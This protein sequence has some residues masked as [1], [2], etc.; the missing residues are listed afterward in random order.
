MRFWP[1]VAVSGHASLSTRRLYS[2]GLDA[3][4]HGIVTA[5]HEGDENSADNEAAKMGKPAHA[6]VSAEEGRRKLENEPEAD[7]PVGG[8]VQW[9]ALQEQTP[10]LH[11]RIK[12]EIG[13]HH[14]R[15]AA[16]GA[17]QRAVR[18]RGDEGMGQARGRPAEQEE[19]DETEMPHGILH[20]VAEHPEKQHVSDQVEQRAVQEDVGGQC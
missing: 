15:Y 5:A 10:D 18:L 11:A 3:G 12:D 19:Q 1:S 7:G 17:D 6:L 13:R 16:G 4:E 20:I 2:L 9:N 14:A 8:K